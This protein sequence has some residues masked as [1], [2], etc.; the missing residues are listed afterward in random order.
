[1]YQVNIQLPAG[2]APGKEVA[3]TITA[4]DS[5]AGVTA[6]SNSVTIAVE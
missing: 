2:I 1:L 3:R 6:Q 5:E 4:A